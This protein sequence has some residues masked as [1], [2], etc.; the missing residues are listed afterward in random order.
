MI[1]VILIGCLESFMILRLIKQHKLFRRGR[2]DVDLLCSVI[3]SIMLFI[4]GGVYSRQEICI[5]IH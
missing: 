2:N 1:Q 4:W 3:L 5:T